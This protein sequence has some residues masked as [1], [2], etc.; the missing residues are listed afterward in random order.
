MET[1]SQKSLLIFFTAL[2][3]VL[4]AAMVGSVAAALT[5]NPPLKIMVRLAR[6][7]KIWAIVAAIGG[8]FSSLEVLEL[9]IFQ[10]QIIALIKQVL[11]LLAAF[12]GAQL[13]HLLIITLAGGS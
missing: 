12:S 4:G 13:G 2:G 7:I 11:Y 6:E 5:G 8:T 1:F 10:G 3:V 9:G